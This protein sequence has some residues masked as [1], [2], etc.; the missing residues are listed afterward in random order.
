MHRMPPSASG[1]EFECLT[2]I[3]LWTLTN[4]SEKVEAILTCVLQIRKLA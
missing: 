3:T 4:P 1:S 2:S